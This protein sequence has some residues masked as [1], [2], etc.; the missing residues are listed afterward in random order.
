MVG[1]SFPLDK[2][3]AYVRLFDVRAKTN[4]SCKRPSLAWKNGGLPTRARGRIK[5]CPRDMCTDFAYRTAV[6]E[7]QTVCEALNMGESIVGRVHSELDS[8]SSVCCCFSSCF[9][10]LAKDC[11]WEW[12]GQLSC[13]SCKRQWIPH[14][15]SAPRLGKP[16]SCF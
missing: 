14:R 12:P 7:V 15:C 16:C 8:F 11:S 1:L 10:C 3:T 2:R 13:C 4:Q 6:W 9:E 5:V